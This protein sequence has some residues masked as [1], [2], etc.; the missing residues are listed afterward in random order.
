[1]CEK[2]RKEKK[3]KVAHYSVPSLGSM[4][5]AAFRVI[6]WFGPVRYYYH[7]LPE[8]KNGIRKDEG[9]S[10]GHI[11]SK[12]EASKCSRPRKKCG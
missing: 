3:E 6:L 9:S 7:C 10:Q 8:E 12:V 1:M 2:G 11:A 4:G 5:P